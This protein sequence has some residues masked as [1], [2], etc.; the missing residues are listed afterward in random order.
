MSKFN[1]GDIVKI[2][3][4]WRNLQIGRIG[5]IN[6]SRGE[7]YNDHINYVIFENDVCWFPDCQLELIK[8]VAERRL[9]ENNNLPKFKIGQSVFIKRTNDSVT[10][11]DVSVD[12]E[13]ISYYVNYVMNY[14]FFQVSTSMTVEEDELIEFE[15]F[16]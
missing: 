1:Q 4:K 8:S 10:I 7:Q 3:G 13:I 2:I 12:G 16:N 15:E 11:N 5:R 14:G 6:E 9:S